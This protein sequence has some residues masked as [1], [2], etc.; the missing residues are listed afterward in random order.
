MTET[1]LE[2]YLGTILEAD[3]VDVDPLHEGLNTMVQVTSDTGAIPTVAGVIDWET[4]FLGDP[5]TELEY[6]SLLWGG[7]TDP[8]PDPA[9][10]PAADDTVDTY[11]TQGFQ[12][13]T[14]R[15]GSPD[16]KTVHDRYTADTGIRF[17]HTQYFQVL[18]AVGL[19]SVWEALDSHDQRHDTAPNR[20]SHVAYLARLADAIVD[21][22][23]TPDW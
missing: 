9:T 4:A 19:A 21:T 17:R 18:A 15:A 8:R 14:T 22:T 16:R 6:V 3:R 10:I 23:A 5:R 2:S 12:P 13:Y 7:D 11:A 20:G 1:A